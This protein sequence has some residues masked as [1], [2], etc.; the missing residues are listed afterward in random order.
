[1]TKWRLRRILIR[2]HLAVSW[3]GTDKNQIVG[4][5]PVRHSAK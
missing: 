4:V 1:M 3:H 2:A 5:V